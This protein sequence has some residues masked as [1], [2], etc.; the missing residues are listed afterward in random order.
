MRRHRRR[1]RGKR[2]E[3]QEIAGFQLL[4]RRGHDGQVEMAVGDGPPMTGHVLHDGQHAA[5]HQA[6][7]HRRAQHRHALRRRRVGTVADDAMTVGSRHIEQGS[8]V[9]VDADSTQLGSC[10]PRRGARRPRCLLH[11]ASVGLAIGCG[12]RQGAPMRRPQ[13]LHPPALLVDEDQDFLADGG[14]H[15]IGQAP[16]LVGIGSIAGKQDDA[17]RARVAQKSCLAPGQARCL[18]VQR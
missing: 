11:I 2:A 6:L 18:P 15:G 12:R 3:R 9:G 4:A 17:A 7:G 5:C 16:Q 13:P 8:A 14:V 1:Q 10:Q